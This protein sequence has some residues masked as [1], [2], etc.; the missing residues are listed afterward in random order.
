MPL[1]LS[2]EPVERIAL[3]ISL[4]GKL[5]LASLPVA[6][7]LAA[8]E[9]LL[10]DLSVPFAFYYYTRKLIYYF[11][12]FNKLKNFLR[13]TLSHFDDLFSPRQWSIR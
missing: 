12:R 7:L 5:D 1:S 6:A 3:F 10:G 4:S 2:Y 9:G 11:I 13:L 8:R